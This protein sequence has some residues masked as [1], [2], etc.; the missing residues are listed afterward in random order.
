MGSS[1]NVKVGGALVI[2]L[3]QEITTGFIEDGLEIRSVGG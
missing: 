1:A 2:F 3:R